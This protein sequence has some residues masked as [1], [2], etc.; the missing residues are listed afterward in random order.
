MAT[1]AAKTNVK[2]LN[3]RSPDTKYV[4]NEPEW[5]VQPTSNRVSKFSNAFGWYISTHRGGILLLV[6]LC[7]GWSRVDR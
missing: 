7:S 6:A 3:P 5:R 2:A 1:L 4:G